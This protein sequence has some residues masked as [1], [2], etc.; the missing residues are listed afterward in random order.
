MIED[1][2]IKIGQ[3]FKGQIKNYIITIVDIKE[4]NNGNIYVWIKDEQGHIV[5][6][7]IKTFKHLLFEAI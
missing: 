7:D 4:E 3:K 5:A 6:P 2:F 1:K